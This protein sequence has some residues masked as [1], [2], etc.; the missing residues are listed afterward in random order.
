VLAKLGVAGLRWNK[1]TCVF[2]QPSIEYLSYINEKDG[3]HPTEEKVRAIKEALKP[4][5]V[6]ELWSFYK[7][8]QKDA[9]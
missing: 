4:R 3:L 2:L 1:P 7:L 9:K 5:N 6:S 8:F